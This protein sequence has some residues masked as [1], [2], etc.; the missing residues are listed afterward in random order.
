M[1]SLDLRAEIHQYIDR[2]DERVI[3]LIYGLVQAD[4]SEEDYE[5]SNA[6]KQILD[7]RLEAHKS[8]PTSG[9]NWHE[10]KARISNEL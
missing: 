4:L 6:H 5:L 7:T 2:A 10:V 3:H 1:S 8:N 9:S